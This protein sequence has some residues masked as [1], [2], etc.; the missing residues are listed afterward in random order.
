P[1]AVAGLKPRDQLLGLPRPHLLERHIET[2]IRRGHRDDV[3]DTRFERSRADRHITAAGGTEPI[4]SVKIEVIDRRLG[5][6]FPGMIH[7]DSLPQGTAL[8][9]PVEGDDGNSKLGQRK[10]E[11]VEL[12]DE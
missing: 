2:R 12:L 3:L 8:A 7:V 4:H 5:W 11:I 6:L 9:R 1:L 10:K